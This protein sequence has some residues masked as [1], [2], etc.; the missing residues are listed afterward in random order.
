MN[1]EYTWFFKPTIY[2][3]LYLIS[4]IAINILGYSLTS[5]LGAPVCLSSIGTIFCACLLGPFGGSIAGIAG[6]V[7]CHVATP[8]LWLYAISCIPISVCISMLYQRTG[9]PNLYQLVCG[10]IITMTISSVISIPL[11]LYLQNGY[12]GNIWGNALVDMLLQQ[13]NGTLFSSILGQLF[14]ELPDKVLS[15][16]AAVMLLKLLAAIRR[17]QEGGNASK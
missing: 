9:M 7:F 3:I 4:G 11:N 13:G 12:T 8:L 14:I 5:S 10:S 1:Q 16:F 15:V 17:Q 6:I 2:N